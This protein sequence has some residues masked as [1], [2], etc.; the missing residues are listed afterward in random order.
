MHKKQKDN[1]NILP[2]DRPRFKKLWLKGFGERKW[3]PLN[4]NTKASFEKIVENA[5]GKSLLEFPDVDTES[6]KASLEVKCRIQEALKKAFIPGHLDIPITATK[7]KL[8]DHL[9]L[10]RKK[11]RQM[12]RA[13]QSATELSDKMQEMQKM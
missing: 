9:E 12:E 1:R 11:T 6:E 13:L 7:E 2:K 4:K 8:N 10:L 3:R 5:V